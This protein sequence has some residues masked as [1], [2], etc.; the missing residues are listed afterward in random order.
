MTGIVHLVGAGPGDPGLLTVRA[1]EL[2]AEADVVLYDRLIPPEALAHARPDAELVYVGKEGEG[3]QVPQADTHALLLE[4]AR[5]GR[6]VVRLK[7][8]DPF[9][10]GRGGEEA[11][12]LSEA[13]VPFEVV[14]GVTA[15]VAAP[16]YAGIPVTHRD[17]ASAVAFVTGH[18][19]PA[20]PET[21]LDWPAL[22]RF[23]GTLVFYM[24]VR[25]LPRIAERLVAGG[26]P[27]SEPVAVVER[28]T[29]PGQR[30]LLATL[31]DVADRAAQERIRAPAITLVGPVARL[32]E[33]LAWLEARPLHGR[34]VA[35]T[36]ARAQASALAARLRTLGAAVVETPAIRIRPL[37]TA[38]PPLRV[39]DLVCVTSPNGAELLMDRLR[40]ARELAGIAVAAIG[41]GTARALRERGIEPDVVPERAVA[42]GLVEALEDMPIKRALI[43]R[44]AEGRDVLPNA[45]RA[46]GV[47]VDVAALYET[48]PEPLADGA[49]EAA[50]DADY[51]L[52]AS[53]S[54]V[55][56]FAQAGGALAGPAAGLDRPGDERRAARP[57][58]RAGR[59]GRAAHPRRAGRRRA[60]GRA[61]MSR[62]ITF[63]SDY[64]LADEF[65]GV[66]HGV[67]A[68]ICPDARVIDLSHGVPRQDVRAGAAMLARALP[69]VAPGVHL[70]VV[71]PEVGARRRA[72]ALRTA[73]QDR[74]LVGPDNGL[75]L[76]AAERFGGIAEVVEISASPWRLE[77]VS[78]TFHGRDLFAPVAARLACG[79]PL[80]AAGTPVEP[81]ELVTAELTQPRHEPGALVAHVVASDTY[82]NAVLDA[83][84]RDLVESGL[85]LGDPVAART[86]SR[87]VRGVVARTF[88]DVA[89]GTLLLYE[90]ASGSLALAVNGGDAA[91]LLGVRAGDEVRLEA[92]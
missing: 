8:G 77:P 49:R 29:L 10:F 45:L 44:A 5:A 86:G 26:R 40:D 61:L 47:E 68:G 54:S 70:A 56:F 22:A 31:R 80:A 43:A 92:G 1:V 59:R 71:D 39:Y 17:T 53:A 11:L 63:L 4:H 75:L 41:P 46:R 9:V 81:G 58:R 67:I 69:Y 57:R 88:S 87:R 16:A 91:A 37:D 30:T 23:P 20:K 12:V 35:V 2:I 33:Q 82:G 55:R 73:E 62:P 6:R 64:G 19:D 21:G 15:G 14:P 60:A 7:G 66:V 78:A 38:L 65:V 74:L 13:G 24:G 3:P 79:E 89:P 76:P 84:H 83:V 18:E 34:T 25:T 42:E 52:F 72:L 36:R 27:E 90:D 48:I 51:L 28:G 32:R 50:A 85:R